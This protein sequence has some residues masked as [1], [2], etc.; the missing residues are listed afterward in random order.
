MKI[1][2]IESNNCQMLLKLLLDTKQTQ[3]ID[4]DC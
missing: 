2:P 4:E 1:C 3:K